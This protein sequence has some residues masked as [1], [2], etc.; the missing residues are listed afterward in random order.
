[1]KAKL[2]FAILTAGLFVVAS[3]GKDDEAPTTDDITTDEGTTDDQT[4]DDIVP[5]PATAEE[6]SII[7]GGTGNS[8][9]DSLIWQGSEYYIAQW[10]R[11]TNDYSTE[12][13]DITESENFKEST[14]WFKKD[15]YTGERLGYPVGKGQWIDRLG[16]TGLTWE[17]EADNNKKMIINKGTGEQEWIIV[18]LTTERF[19]FTRIWMGAKERMV[20]RK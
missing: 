4:D 19:E 3:C 13:E 12:E 14:F 9:D 10:D 15:K 1:M 20:L 16:K 18:S 5:K 11:S 7:I 6:R 2:L 8:F 17:M